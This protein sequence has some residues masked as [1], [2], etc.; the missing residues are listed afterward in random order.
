MP[1]IPLFPLN[2]VLLPGALLP[3]HIFEERYRD[4]IGRCLAEQREFGVTWEQEMESAEGSGKSTQVEKSWAQI[5]CS[6]RILQVLERYPDGRLDILT[7]GERRFSIHSVDLVS[8]EYAQAKVTFFE[9]D[10][11][12][13]GEETAED[14]ETL[15]H[16]HRRIL[17]LQGRQ[18]DDPPAGPEAD[19]GFFL[20]Q[21]LE[22]HWNL[23][24]QLLA[25]RSPAVRVRY[26]SAY[27]E[28]L[29][30][31]LEQAQTMRRTVAGNGHLHRRRESADGDR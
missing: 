27:Y 4:M 20:G 10:P 6:A 1:L 21:C 19:L 17:A 26:L 12:A 23:K 8:E 13:A 25:L 22:E 11:E 2:L 31:L 7:R 9:D 3:L 24:Q 29:L 14:R 30:P 16:M 28:R 5:G 15:L 18:P